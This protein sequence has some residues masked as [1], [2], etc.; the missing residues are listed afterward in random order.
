MVVTMDP[1][2][3][4]NGRV[5][6]LDAWDKFARAFLVLCVVGLAVVF[7]GGLIYAMLTPWPMP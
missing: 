7:L 1:S 3:G 4:Q 2:K 6:Q 5:H